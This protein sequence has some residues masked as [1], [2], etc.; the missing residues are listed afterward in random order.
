MTGI[1]QISPAAASAFQTTKSLQL[2]RHSGPV[3]FS[4][5]P[6]QPGTAGIGGSTPSPTQA[7]SAPS[8]GNAVTGP[9]IARLT[10]G[11]LA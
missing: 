11:I 1:A 7:A 5:P 2:G 10:R 8:S 3:K 6:L 9:A 4:L